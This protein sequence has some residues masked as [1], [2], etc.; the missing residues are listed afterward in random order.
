MSNQ[1]QQ[2]ENKKVRVNIKARFIDKQTQEEHK[3]YEVVLDTSKIVI[4]SLN[5]LEDIRLPFKIN[6]KE[7]DK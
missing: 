5:D 2:E 1:N 4:S 7:A 3:D 6:R